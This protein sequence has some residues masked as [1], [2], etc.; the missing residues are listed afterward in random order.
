MKKILTSVALATMVSGSVFAACSAAIDMNTNKIENL[1]MS[2][3]GYNTLTGNAG[4][5]DA[6]TKAYVDA[7]AGPVCSFVTYVSSE[8]WIRGDYPETACGSG[9][10]NVSVT[11]Q[12]EL[13]ACLTEYISSG[14]TRT[15]YVQLLT[16]NV[17]GTDATKTIYLGVSE[18]ILGTPNGKNYTTSLAQIT[19]NGDFVDISPTGTPPANS[20][21][22]NY[23]VSNA[24]KTA[25]YA[26]IDD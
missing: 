24:S 23:I 19:A 14:Q 9:K 7:V 18:Y 17:I 2:E 21:N 26:C 25:N 3:S 6:A 1:V 16:N 8:A 12:T 13:D 15:A 22:S 4:D 5:N 10:H 20:P 11:N